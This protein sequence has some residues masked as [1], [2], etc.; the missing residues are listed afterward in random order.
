ME[1]RMT[2]NQIRQII[3]TVINE[4]EVNEW[5]YIENGEID[6]AADRIMNLWDKGFTYDIK[7]EAHAE[8]KR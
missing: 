4:I 6:K 2:R 3:R 5:A 1:C 8:T 7:E